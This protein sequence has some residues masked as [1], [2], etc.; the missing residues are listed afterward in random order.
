[1]IDFLTSPK[2]SYVCF[3][4]NTFFALVSLFVGNAVFF[5]TNLIFAAICY[6]NYLAHEETKNDK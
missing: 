3:I 2:T 1:M 6:N 5:M 4:L